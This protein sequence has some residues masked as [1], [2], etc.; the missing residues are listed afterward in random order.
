MRNVVIDF[1]KIKSDIISLLEVN[2]I[3]FDK[4]SLDINYS[5]N[6]NVD[7]KYLIDKLNTQMD[8]ISQAIKDRSWV[9]VVCLLGRIRVSFIHLSDFFYNIESDIKYLIDGEK[10]HYCG[11]DL[12][13]ENR[14]D[15]PNDSDIFMVDLG[16][17]KIKPIIIELTEFN[18]QT[19]AADYWKLDYRLDF[20]EYF[21]ET[22]SS[23]MSCFEYQS[24]R[25]Y[26]KDLRMLSIKL[27]NAY[28]LCKKLNQF[29]YAACAD[30][31]NLAW[32]ENS[33]LPDIPEGYTLP[34]KY[35][36]I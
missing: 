8:S 2:C 16:F 26:S 35:V 27:N 10:A 32:S 34:A 1:E 18:G 19:M 30:I 28:L 11:K 33:N 29:F 23:L 9:D 15:A 3:N 22:V 25:A 13:S 6:L 5:I 7:F 21:R 12:N 14:F 17:N 36:G 31:E 4:D 20:D 24:I